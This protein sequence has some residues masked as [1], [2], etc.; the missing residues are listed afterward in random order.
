MLNTSWE[1]G[2]ATGN[3]SIKSINPFMCSTG[4]NTEDTYGLQDRTFGIEIT[5]SE[6]QLKCSKKKTKIDQHTCMKKNV[7]TINLSCT[8]T[9]ITSGHL[10]SRQPHPSPIEQ[11]LLIPHSLSR[12]DICQNV[13][14]EGDN[15]YFETASP[16]WK[17]LWHNY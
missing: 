17:H 15:E 1:E 12:W 4:H 3:Q 6:T 7:R 10:V 14:A 11:H 16:L 13:S 9:A 8:T 2:C 5:E